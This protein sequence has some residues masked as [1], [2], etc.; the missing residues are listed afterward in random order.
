M[1]NSEKKLRGNEIKSQQNY[2]WVWYKKLLS[3][4]NKLV[5]INSKE[6]LWNLQNDIVK[7]INVLVKEGKMGK[8]NVEYEYV[9]KCEVGNEIGKVIEINGDEYRV[10]DWEVVKGGDIE[11]VFKYDSKE[12]SVEKIKIELKVIE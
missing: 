3:K 1:E 2:C 12:D 9:I 10:D 8:Y 5:Y 7:K 11:L 6:N 4:N